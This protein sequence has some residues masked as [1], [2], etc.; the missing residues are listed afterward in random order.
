[1][2]QKRKT[3]TESKK[4][5]QNAET[6]ISGMQ[7]QA[8]NAKKRKDHG[9]GSWMEKGFTGEESSRNTLM[10]LRNLR[11]LRRPGMQ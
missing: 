4:R 6:I 7:S 9:M 10:A 1:M 11:N 3:A 5:S 8:K 2:H